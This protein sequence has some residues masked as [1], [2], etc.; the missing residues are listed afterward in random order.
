MIHAY[1]GHKRYRKKG[2][3]DRYTDFATEWKTGAWNRFGSAWNVNEMRRNRVEQLSNG[4]EN[5]RCEKAFHR[6]DGH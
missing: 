1:V 3:N 6:S 5:K 2:W 4:F